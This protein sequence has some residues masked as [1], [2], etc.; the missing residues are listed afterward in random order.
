MNFSSRRFSSPLLVQLV[1]LLCACASLWIVSTAFAQSDP[2][3]VVT[4]EQVPDPISEGINDALG[5]VGSVMS[6]SK[7]SSNLR[8]QEPDSEQALTKIAP[9][10]GAALIVVLQSAKN[11]VKVEFRN[12]RNGSVLNKTTVPARAARGKAPKFSKPARKKIIAMAKRSLK[13]V[14]PA[15]PAAAV[16]KRESAADEDED[17]FEAPA[18]QP[19]RAA[20]PSKPSRPVAPVKQA[21]RDEEDEAESEEDEEQASSGW[22]KSGSDDDEEP[23]EKSAGSKDKSTWWRLHAGLGLGSRSIVVPAPADRAR[24]N[25]V[26]TAFAPS[27]EIGAGVELGLGPAWRLRFLADYR[28]IFGI[29]ASYVTAM[30][31]MAQA[32]FSSNSL[33][34]GASL[35]HLSDGQDSF[36]FHVFVG[37]AWRSLAA[38]APALPSASIQ[39]VVLRPELEIPIANRKVTLRLAPELILILVPSATLPMVDSGLKGAV[40]FALG[41][42]ASIDWHISQTFSLSAQFRESR[43]ST[44]SGHGTSAIENERYLALRLMLQF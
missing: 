35:G 23:R 38:S 31:T 34:A 30:G 24:G 44:P 25:K 7:Y 3:L 22:D 9:Q 33:V 28:T 1:A 27:L 4:G 16:S 15:P 26:D 32:S 29:S 14:P 17:E 10:T 8:G 13:K 19:S 6:S 37:W 41:A 21:A 40:G 5:D 20:T 12:G 42:E 36:G 2:I 39:G 18:A 43:G 11:K